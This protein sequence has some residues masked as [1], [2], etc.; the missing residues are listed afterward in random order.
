MSVAN[1]HSNGV[2]ERNWARLVFYAASTAWILIVDTLTFWHLLVTRPIQT[3]KSFTSTGCKCSPATCSP[4][5][6]IPNSA[7]G[8]LGLYRLYVSPTTLQRIQTMTNSTTRAASVSSPVSSSYGSSSRS[9]SFLK[10]SSMKGTL[11]NTSSKNSIL[12]TVKICFTTQRKANTTDSSCKISFLPCLT[13]LSWQKI[14]QNRTKENSVA[15]SRKD[16]CVM[17]TTW[18]TWCATSPNS[19]REAQTSLCRWQTARCHSS[20]VACL[21]VW[22][23]NQKNCITMVS[24]KEK[25]RW[26]SYIFLTGSSLA[27]K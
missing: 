23:R 5:S 9:I 1:I 6:S 20:T 17:A 18:T 7:I 11:E 15:T 24:L 2:T 4:R 14:R 10:S 3:T 25:S 8:M 22:I 16:F 13:A 27:K 21:T 26:N 19:R 12:T